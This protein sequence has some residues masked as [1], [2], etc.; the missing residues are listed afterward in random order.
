MTLFAVTTDGVGGHAVATRSSFFAVPQCR[1]VVAVVDVVRIVASDRSISRRRL[2]LE[3]P[4][5]RVVAPASGKDIQLGF[6]RRCLSRQILHGG[7]S[8]H[9]L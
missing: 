8:E 5:R 1:G 4:R 2:G 3:K 7:N 6:S 9:L